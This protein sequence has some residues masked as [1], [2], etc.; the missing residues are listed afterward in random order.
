M[1]PKRSPARKGQ[2]PMGAGPRAG[3]EAVGSLGDRVI[4]FGEEEGEKRQGPMA[5]LG[6]I[7]LSSIMFSNRTLLLYGRLLV[8]INF[9]FILYDLQGKYLYISGNNNFSFP[10]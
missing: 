10:I 3:G 2:Q 7:D 1:E 8:P 4:C 5:C 6:L 9:S